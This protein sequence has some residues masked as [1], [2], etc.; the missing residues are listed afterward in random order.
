M[1]GSK[2]KTPRAE[3][4]GSASIQRLA[5]RLVTMHRPNREINGIVRA[6]IELLESNTPGPR[7]SAGIEFNARTLT[8]RAC[9]PPPAERPT[10]EQEVEN[11]LTADNV[12][13]MT[14][15]DLVAE[16][17]RRGHEVNAQTVIR[18]A[19][20]LSA[21]GRGEYIFRSRRFRNAAEFTINLARPPRA[22]DL[23]D[24][25]S[26]DDDTDPNVCSAE[27]YV[28]GDSDGDSDGDDDDSDGDE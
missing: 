8:A 17:V 2:G 18:Y 28:P 15:D 10:T 7:P 19:K 23:W 24:S 26:D 25:D 11:I 14:T 13:W 21:Q 16:V 1:K 9:T 3:A 5:Q 20:N 6:R 4:A 22:D 12:G 27:D